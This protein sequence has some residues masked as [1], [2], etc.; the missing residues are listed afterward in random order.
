MFIYARKM[1]EY[2]ACFPT[3][4]SGAPEAACLNGRADE[5]KRKCIF[6]SDVRP[7]RAFDR[8]SE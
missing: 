2:S 8:S 3:G 6:R 4:G 1:F 7:A 5:L